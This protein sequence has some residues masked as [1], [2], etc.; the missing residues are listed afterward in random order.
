DITL[1]RMANQ[2]I[3]TM[4]LGRGDLMGAILALAAKRGRVVVTNLHAAT[5]TAVTMSLLDM[6]LMEKQVVGSLFGSA[7]PRADIP[8]L[9][10]LYR[11]GQFDLD[12]MVTQTYDLD[13]VNQGYDD[14]K[15][16]KNIRGILLFS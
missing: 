15:A 4:G 14:M 2:V 6:T 3:V 16:G 8:R 1:G 9:L 5:E 10:E 11:N 7:N 12:G 13:G